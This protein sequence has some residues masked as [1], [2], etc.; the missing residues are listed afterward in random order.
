MGVRGPGIGEGRT[1][2]ETAAP[3]AGRG[4]QPER[5]VH[6]Q[7]RAPRPG[8]RRDLL[9]R[10]ARSGVHV[11]ELGTDD[12]RPRGPGD[13]FAQRVGPHPS[14][15]VHRHRTHAGGA[16][17]EEAQRREDR[18]VR[19]G[20]DDH[21]DLRSAEQAALLDVPTRAPQHGVACRREAGGVRHLAAGDEADARRGR[22][23]E[24]T[25]Q[26][27]GGHVLD[28]RRGRTEDVEASVLIPDRREPIG[29]DG[30]GE[31]AADNEPEVARPA[32]RD[33][34][35]VG[36][37]RQLG[38]DLPGVHALFGQRATQGRGHLGGC[39][40]RPD[41]ARGD[42]G[43]VAPRKIGG[44]G[45]RVRSGHDM[46]VACPGVANKPSPPTNRPSTSW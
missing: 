22:E 24:Q 16:H 23:T 14:L 36:G 43:E 41:G 46:I 20:A 19:L 32:R 11:A 13:R 7:P 37:A 33:D 15:P 29:A 25:Q 34:A 35:G 18:H 44:D 45:E 26:P 5:A 12:G 27:A 38:D 28:H 21:L 39:R 2:G 8:Q 17:P 30:G 40:A 3:R 6:V 10:I 9:E 42:A 1:G 31:A 4:P